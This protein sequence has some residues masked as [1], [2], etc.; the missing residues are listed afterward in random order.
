MSTERFYPGRRAASYGFEDGIPTK[1][2]PHFGEATGKDDS[3]ALPALTAAPCTQ[4]GG[5]GS[6]PASVTKPMKPA[7]RALEVPPAVLA[8]LCCALLWPA[9]ALGQSSEE[10][11]ENLPAVLAKAVSA[12]IEKTRAWAE[13]GRARGPIYFDSAALDSTLRSL[14]GE[15]FSFSQGAF[16]AA[17][18]PKMRGQMHAGAKIEEARRKRTDDDPST[19]EVGDER[20]NMARNGLFVEVTHVKKARGKYFVLLFTGYNE[21][22]RMKSNDGI[23]WLRMEYFVE[24]KGGSW[25]VTLRDAGNIIF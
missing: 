1:R 3:N 25:S 16:R 19:P 12:G 8:F 11:G 20:Y 6:S 13:P 2:A 5:G 15:S 7:Q 18:P 10:I 4:R 21:S 22:R 23:G 9:T 14:F 24:Q 17:L